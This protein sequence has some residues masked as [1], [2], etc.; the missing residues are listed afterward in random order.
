MRFPAKN[1]HGTSFGTSKVFFHLKTQVNAGINAEVIIDTFQTIVM[2]VFCLAVVS[3]RI[4]E[5]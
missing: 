4:R 2:A 3:E 1:L 5:D